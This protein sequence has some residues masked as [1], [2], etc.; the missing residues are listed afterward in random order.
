MESPD[1][2]SERAIALAA[3]GNKDAA[4][5]ELIRLAGDDPGPLEAARK[6][7]VKRLGMNSNDYAASTGLTLVN[8]ALATVGW[9]D[10]VAWKPRVWR[11]SRKWR[12][13]N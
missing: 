6:V 4:I 3:E 11:I 1:R 12:Q 2:I 9:S 5:N 8:A 10:P 7:L 13:T